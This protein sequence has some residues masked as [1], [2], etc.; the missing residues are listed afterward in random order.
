MRGSEQQRA[1]CRDL[2]T[3]LKKEIRAP[4]S[5]DPLRALLA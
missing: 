3:L 2:I 4:S 5:L 1:D